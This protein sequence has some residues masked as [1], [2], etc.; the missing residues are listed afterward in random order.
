MPPEPNLPVSARVA[1]WE[2]YAPRARAYAWRRGRPNVYRTLVSELMLQQTQARRVEPAFRSF[3]RR[4]PTVASLA[5]ASRADVVRAWAGLGY[6]RRAVHLH[7][8][9]QV[10]VR[11]HDGRVPQD[12][13]ALRSLPGV[14]PYTAAAVASIAGGVPVAA[15]DVNVRRV[16]ERVG[17]GAGA[18]ARRSVD[19]TAQRW[20]DRDDPGGWNQALMDIGREHCRVVPR[21]DG[22]PLVRV[23]R[24]KRVNPAGGSIERGPS[25]Q[26]PF[27]GSA[28]EV[29]GRVV[30]VLRARRSAGAAALAH[31]TG[32][33]ASRVGEALDGLIRDGVVERAGRSYRLPT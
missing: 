16:V 22:C 20:V 1:V 12:V 27:A 19:T 29:R 17:F 8:A 25:R 13:E 5:R 24:W 26:G 10:V 14:G 23:C 28:R 33:E 32:F 30:D 11:D 2:W 4:F 15:I 9:A 31:A 21:C 6:N 3:V 7:A 18:P